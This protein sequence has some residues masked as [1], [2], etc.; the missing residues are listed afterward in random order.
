MQVS[1]FFIRTLVSG[2]V[3]ERRF[4]AVFEG[5]KLSSPPSL[6]IKLVPKLWHE[7]EIPRKKSTDLHRAPHKMVILSVGSEKRVASFDVLAEKVKAKHQMDSRC[8][9]VLPNPYDFNLFM[10]QTR[11]V[12]SFHV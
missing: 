5:I 8:M 12:Y 1:A 9:S 2:V 4:C 3:V 7:S 11:H 10:P 6:Q